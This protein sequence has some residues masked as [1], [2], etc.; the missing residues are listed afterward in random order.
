MYGEQ[1]IVKVFNA[2]EKMIKNFN[3]NN[4]ILYES[5]WKSQFLTGLMH[6]IMNFVSN[7]G[8]AVIALLGGYY[9]IKGKISV[10]SIQ[11]F[12]SYNKHF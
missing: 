4:D 12:I 9:A 8:Y 7:I 5:A 1:S 10:G 2:E 3:E 11:S 6:P